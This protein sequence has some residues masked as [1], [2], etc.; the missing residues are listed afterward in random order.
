MKYAPV[1]LA[2]KKR[3]TTSRKRQSEQPDEGRKTEQPGQFDPQNK[4]IA[5]LS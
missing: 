1:P 2:P 4:Q 3:S 5:D